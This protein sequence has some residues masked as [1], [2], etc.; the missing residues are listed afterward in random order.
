MKRILTLC[1]LVCCFC[2]QLAAQSGLENTK[3]ENWT[4]TL[5]QPSPE[6]FVSYGASEVTSGNPEGSSALK[7]TTSVFTDNNGQKD[8][9][10]QSYIATVSGNSVVQGDAI[11]FCPDSITGYVKY[12]LPNNDSAVLQSGVKPAGGNLVAAATRFYEGTQSSWMKFNI[13]YSPAGCN[14]MTPDTITLFLAS[15]TGPDSV[16]GTVQFDG[17]KV[18]NDGSAVSVESLVKKGTEYKAYPT[19]A[20]RNVRF[21]F[22]DEAERIRIFDMTGREVRAHRISDGDKA[23]V[24]VGDLKEGLYLYRIE[25][26]EGRALHSDK[27]QVRE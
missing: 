22:G 27:L 4:T 24:Q 17:L 13:Q 9:V 3:F 18:W 15:T 7:I 5:G 1:S 2:L 19:P 23:R 8:T 25:D 10:G 14:G 12:D 11:S 21:E 6:G 16:G 20:S 26:G